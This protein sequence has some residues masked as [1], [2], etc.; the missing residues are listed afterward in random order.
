[1]QSNPVWGSRYLKA[2]YPSPALPGNGLQQ[3]NQPHG[4]MNGMG[5]YVTSGQRWIG[6]GRP[7]EE[8]WNEDYPRYCQAKTELL[9]ANH[10]TG[11]PEPPANKSNFYEC[12][13]C[14]R[15]CKSSSLMAFRMH[16]Y[17]HHMELS[18]H[19]RK[20]MLMAFGKLR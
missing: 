17:R 9:L 5:V 6:R 2:R 19:E 7:I 18:A 4:D 8:P 16:L 3:Q 1:M 13:L 15:K 12:S 14:H 11:Q 10:E 20:S